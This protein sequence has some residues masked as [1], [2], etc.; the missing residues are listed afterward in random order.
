MEC[1]ATKAGR[2][3]GIRILG[4]REEPIVRNDCGKRHSLASCWVSYPL[5]RP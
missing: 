5:T 2:P 1:G 3:G 4:R